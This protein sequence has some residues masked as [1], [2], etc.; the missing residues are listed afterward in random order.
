VTGLFLTGSRF[1]I[2]RCYAHAFHQGVNVPAANIASSPVQL[3]AEHA[4]AHERVFQMQF[5]NPPHQGQVGTGNRSGLIVDAAPAYSYQLG[6]P[7]H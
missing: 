7:F 5:V 4:G 2:Q 6:L 3:I 1:A